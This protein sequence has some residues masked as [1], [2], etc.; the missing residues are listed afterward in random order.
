ASRARV[1][2]QLLLESLL[3]AGISGVAGFVLADLAVRWCD[4]NTQDIGKPPWMAFTID[5][6][7]VGFLVLVCA[8]TAV[9]FGLVPA[10]YISKT[11]VH[12]VLKEGGRS[13]SGGPRARR[14]T[15]ALVVAELTLTL[16]LLSGAGFM[17]RSFLNL[18]SMDVGV[19]ASH[20]L[21]MRVI[22]PATRYRSFD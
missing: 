7:V 11:N 22:A 18:Y 21:T 6:R 15:T 20:L 14:W 12:D 2:R 8:A 19:D 17:I 16:V 3:L 4:A 13:A 9:L 10:L 5:A 1:V